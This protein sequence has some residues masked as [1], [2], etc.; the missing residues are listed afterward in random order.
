[1]RIAKALAQYGICSRRKAEEL[2][3]QQ[4]VSVNHSIIA[5]PVYFVAA[6]DIISVDGKIIDSNIPQVKI[7]K[8]F[9]PKAVITSTND[10][11]GRKTVFDL[12][13]RSIG[14]VMTVGR[15]DYNTEGLLLLT[16][17]GAI[18]RKFELPSSGYQRKY[19]CRAF[20][21]IPPDMVKRLASGTSINGV[22]YRQVKM[23][24][25]SS[26][27]NNNWSEITLYEG[28][29]REIRKLFSYFGLQVNRLIR[30]SY[31]PYELGEMQPRALQ[32]IEFSKQ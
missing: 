9:K 30:I 19:L 25:K 31:G 15:L 17:N 28:K 23:K 3:Y 27:G 13:P 12:L 32:E 10:T 16:N 7:W 14:R 21:R 18:A 26:V 11:K 4:R 20:G 1:M 29:N 6:E 8:F 5:T 24:V 2:I 22:H